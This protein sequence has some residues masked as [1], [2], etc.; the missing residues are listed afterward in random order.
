MS[1][2]FDLC[3]GDQVVDVLR[4]AK[5]EVVVVAPFIK[6]NALKRIVDCINSD[7]VK[8][9][10]VTRW[11]PQDIAAGVC[12]IEI[13]ELLKRLPNAN[14]WMNKR[15]HAKYVRADR[16]CLTGSANLTES[17][18]GWRVPSNLELMVDV[19]SVIQDMKDWE[20]Q[21]FDCSTVVNKK[22]RDEIQSSSA[23]L[24]DKGQHM[25]YVEFHV[26]ENVSDSWL[27]Q[28]ANPRK[29]YRVYSKEVTSENMPKSSFKYAMSDLSALGIPAGLSEENFNVAVASQ[30]S[31]SSVIM[32]ILRA[33]EKS[34]GAGL[35]VTDVEKIVMTFKKD[36]NVNGSEGI[37]PRVVEWIDHFLVEYR[38]E[39]EVVRLVR[40]IEI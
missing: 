17:A 14:L 23:T 8:I 15:L 10:C 25:Q 28:Y 3:V 13:Y 16:K 7:K 30:I 21:L 20:E 32:E 18:L 19:S 11:L 38:A 24:I 22:T 6:V 33:S 5:K 12:D 31:A 29:L 34:K 35:S 4:G 27:P 40:A 36:V 2:M 39:S 9:D 1:S 26:D 37:G